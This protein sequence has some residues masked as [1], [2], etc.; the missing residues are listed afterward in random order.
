VCG[1]EEPGDGG[2]AVE[3]KLIQSLFR[4]LELVSD[5]FVA[6]SPA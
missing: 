5:F 1:C 4:A 2:G 6:R 3:C